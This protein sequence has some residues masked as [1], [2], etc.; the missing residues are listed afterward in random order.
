RGR[1]RRGTAAAALAVLAAAAGLLL[2]EAGL[3]LFHPQLYQRP[4][5]WQYDDR[6]GW[7]HIPSA[8][9]RL[10]SPEFDVEITINADGLRD[11]KYGRRR[12][13]GV[14]RI[15]VFG[16]SF[17]EGWGVE[18]D[19]PVSEQLE[20]LL[21]RADGSPPEVLNCGVAGYGTDQELLLFGSL[22]REL[23]PDLAIV[24]F[25][26]NDLWN[27]AS[28]RGIGAERGYKPFFRPGP[29]G[30]LVLRGVP[31]PR[32]PFWDQ[33]SA[34]RA[35][36]GQRLERYLGERWHLYALARRALAPELSAGEQR[37]FYGGLYGLDAAGEYGQLWDLTARLL[38][39]FQGQVRAAGAQLLLVYA[40]AIVQVDGADWRA[41]R[42][43]HGLTGDYDLQKPQ[44]LLAAIAARHRIDFLDLGPTFAQQAQPEKL[45]FRDSHWTPAGHGLAAAAIADHLNR[46]S[47][48]SSGGQA[49]P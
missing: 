2:A 47:A 44:R 15:L 9:G 17:A 14:E 34:N 1:L 20:A 23:T 4:K 6:L 24:L 29:D 30:S 25:Y 28:P 36:A 7:A 38:A 19:Q 43:L 13:A 5:V 42:Q 12:P 18:Q 31:V 41:K 27:N 45:Y 8:S 3:A 48:A 37:A 10:V 35:P 46:R 33:E 40:P 26:G 22:G 21:A 11:C 39:E 16:D 32:S 49:L